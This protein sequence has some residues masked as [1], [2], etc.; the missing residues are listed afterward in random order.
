LL[1]VSGLELATFGVA[2]DLTTRVTYLV[3]LQPD[4]V[5]AND[6][7]DT[8][9]RLAE[10]SRCHLVVAFLTSQ[11]CST[12]HVIYQLAGEATVHT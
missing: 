1:L 3:V 7:S 11:S 6:R 4:R 10:L 8:D 12:F 5:I 2:E 9:L